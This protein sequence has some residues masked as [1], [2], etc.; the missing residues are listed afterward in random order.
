VHGLD[1]ATR[2]T[3]GW[4]RGVRCRPSTTTNGLG[5]CRDLVIE[6]AGSS[7]E[8]HDVRAGCC[9]LWLMRRRRTLSFLPLRTLLC[10]ATALSALAGFAPS[11]AAA[12]F[13]SSVGSGSTPTKITCG[14]VLPST[15]QLHCEEVLAGFGQDRPLCG[16]FE[17][18]VVA[19]L[20]RTGQA[21]STRLCTEQSSLWTAGGEASR[22]EAGAQP[23]LAGSTLRLQEGFSCVIGAQ[24]V[25]CRNSRRRGFRITAGNVVQRAGA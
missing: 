3:D 22:S 9:L 18:I 12:N 10:V 19:S 24:S 21:S 7:P 16:P 20:S 4:R 23:V 17:L 14:V 13:Y 15:P 5:G 6:G 8:K 2:E 11:E 25:L 1:E